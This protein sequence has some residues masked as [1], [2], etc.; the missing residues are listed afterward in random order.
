MSQEIQ[1]NTIFDMSKDMS[2]YT[3]ILNSY[4]AT[5]FWNHTKIIPNTKWVP[6][7]SHLCHMRTGYGLK[8][9]SN[10]TII[11]DFLVYPSASYSSFQI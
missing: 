8:Q 9:Y 3:E 5:K 7:L 11:S 10:Q 4:L 6:Q 1:I 2:A